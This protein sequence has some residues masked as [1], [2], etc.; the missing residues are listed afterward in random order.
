[1][2][3]EYQLYD[4]HFGQGD[5]VPPEPETVALQLLS[6]TEIETANQIS[7]PVKTDSQ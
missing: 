1:M 5:T 4:Y 6:E 7:E 2:F 3:T